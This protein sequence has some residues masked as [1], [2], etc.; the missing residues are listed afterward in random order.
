MREQHGSD[1]RLAG[2]GHQCES[3]C[4]EPN[5]G[6][7]PRQ[8]HDPTEQALARIRAT[9]GITQDTQSS[10]RA[11]LPQPVASGR[12]NARIAGA[13]AKHIQRLLP[14]L[15]GRFGRCSP[16]DDLG[17]LSQTTDR[18][19]RIR[20]HPKQRQQ[21]VA[22]LHQSC[23]VQ[24]HRR[25][26]LLQCSDAGFGVGQ[27]VQASQ[28][29]GKLLVVCLPACL[30]ILDRRVLDRGCRRALQRVECPGNQAARRRGIIP[31]KVNE[32]VRQ[33]DSNVGRD[34]HSQGIH[35]RGTTV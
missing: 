19:R 26:N 8:C 16:T 14:C 13:A 17:Q 11:P 7:A 22:F 30:P 33:P 20:Q 31:V 29:R 12:G 2:L 25:S 3:L 27:G 23:W 18:A 35:Q 6:R 1:C 5:V 10:F 28:L 32:L 9:D 15:C 4:V 21:S 24:R 34:S